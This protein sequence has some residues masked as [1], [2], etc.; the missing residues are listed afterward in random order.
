MKMILPWANIDNIWFTMI[1]HRYYLFMRVFRSFISVTEVRYYS[2]IY[3]RP[4][5]IFYYQHAQANGHY[6]SFLDIDWF[7]SYYVM[8]I[9]GDLHDTLLRHITGD[10]SG[11]RLKSSP[12]FLPMPR[13]AILMCYLPQ[14][15]RIVTQ[16]AILNTITRRMVIYSA[17]HDSSVTA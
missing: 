13:H 12:R 5:H 6:L 3:H 16:L 14:S 15:A 10:A 7:E 1:A 8:M 9:W 4:Y 11:H 17:P 2:H